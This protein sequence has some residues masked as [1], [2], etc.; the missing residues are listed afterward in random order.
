[1]KQYAFRIGLDCHGEAACVA[2]GDTVETVIEVASDSVGGGVRSAVRIT[3]LIQALA[4]CNHSVAVIMQLDG[5]SKTAVPVTDSLYSNTALVFIDLRVID[6]DGIPIRVS[7]P[8]SI[9][10]WGSDDGSANQI[11][12]TRPAEGG[13]RGNRYTAG[14]EAS[15]RGAPGS[16][17]LQV[18]LKNAWNEALGAVSECVLLEQVVQVKE[19]DGLNTV[20]LSVAS[21]SGCALLVGVILFWARR[22]ST[23]LRHVLVMV[24]TESSKTVTSISFAIGN[25]STDLYTTYRVVFEGLVKSR[26]YRVPYAVF[27]CLSIVAGLLSIYF[28]VRRACELRLHIK[29]NSEVEQSDRVY[30]VTQEPAEADTDL[31]GDEHDASHAVVHKLKWELQRTS[32]DL[33]GLAVGVLCLL[34]EDLPMVCIYR[35]P[36]QI[37]SR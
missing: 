3:T 20:W 31:E 29:T 26:L 33:K 21:L 37:V 30:P 4:S 7:Q 2:D 11:V 18:L 25:L 6:A 12:P 22:M 24:L 27:G 10:F 8:A 14:I 32:R 9:V 16:Y 23:E 15:L 35:R 36:T 17:R 19:P 5:S 1:M 28:H 13:S 34:L